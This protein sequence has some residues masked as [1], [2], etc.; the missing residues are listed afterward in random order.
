MKNQSRYWDDGIQP[1]AEGY[2]VCV[3][4]FGSNFVRYTI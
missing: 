2:F 1:S 3:Q 4:R